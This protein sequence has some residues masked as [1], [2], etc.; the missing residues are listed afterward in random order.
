MRSLFRSK[1]LVLLVVTAVACGGSTEPP[2]PVSAIVTFA[3][4]GDA[5]D[6]MNVLV[7][8]Q[9]TIAAAQ[10]Y[11]ATHR[12]PHLLAGTIVRGAGIDDRYPFQFVPESVEIIDAA[13]EVCDGTPMRTEA[14][15]ND[16]FAASLG[17]R[18]APAATWCPWSSYPI[19]VALLRVEN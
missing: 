8:R 2:G 5:A 15:V 17:N 7:T 11:I 10:A 13:V 1:S 18:N 6:T 14:A 4:N 3:F 19:K 16:F 12:G 9:S